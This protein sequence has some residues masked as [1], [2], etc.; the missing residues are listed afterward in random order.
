MKSLVKNLI[1]SYSCVSYA[2]AFAAPPVAPFYESVMKMNPTGALGEVIKKEQIPTSL[3]GAQAWKIAYISSDVGERKTI[4]T[5]LIIA[6]V[7]PAPAEGR[8][9]MAWAHRS[10]ERRVGKE[11]SL[12]CRSR[13]SPYH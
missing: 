3:K 10:E 13:W 1:L 12:P 4:A 5:A 8:P 7:G 11:C 6:P 2:S 9:I